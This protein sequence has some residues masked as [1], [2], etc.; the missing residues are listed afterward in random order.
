MMKSWRLALLLLAAS[1]VVMGYHDLARSSSLLTRTI[2][3]WVRHWFGGHLLAQAASVVLTGSVE[4]VS[5]VPTCTEI[6]DDGDTITHGSS[7]LGQSAQDQLCSADNVTIQTNQVTVIQ[8]SLRPGQGAEGAEE[9]RFQAFPPVDAS[10]GDADYRALFPCS[11]VPEGQPCRVFNQSALTISWRTSP[12]VSRYSLRNRGL[13]VPFAYLDYYSTI[14]ADDDQDDGPNETPVAG[15]HHTTNKRNS[16]SDRTS[17]PDCDRVPN[18]QCTDDDDSTLRI[19]SEERPLFMSQPCERNCRPDNCEGGWNDALA[20]QPAADGDDRQ[21]VGCFAC[22]AGYDKPQ[23]YPGQYGYPHRISTLQQDMVDAYS[24]LKLATTSSV[25]IDEGG[26][27]GE[28]PVTALAGSASDCQAGAAD[29][30]CIDVS[31]AQAEALLEQCSPI[32]NGERCY[33][34]FNAIQGASNGVFDQYQTQLAG[35]VS[36]SGA[37]AFD[38]LPAQAVGVAVTPFFASTRPSDQVSEPTQLTS[39]LLYRCSHGCG[40]IATGDREFGDDQ[41]AKAGNIVDAKGSMPLGPYCSAFDIDPQARG[42]I[43]VQLTLEYPGADGTLQTV[44]LDLFSDAAIG[45]SSGSAPGVTAHLEKIETTST[46]SVGRYLDGLI[47]TCGA[48]NV[49]GL[50]DGLASPDA[51][52]LDNPW[53]ALRRLAACN[54]DAASLSQPGCQ[55]YDQAMGRSTAQSPTADGE[56][57]TYSGHLPRGCAVPIPTFLN[58]I[59]TD[60]DVRA[61]RAASWFYVPPALERAYC[62]ECGCYGMPMDFGNDQSTAELICGS[63]LAG[64]PCTPGR[65][66][67]PAQ[68]AP[69]PCLSVGALAQFHARTSTVDPQGA[70]AGSSSAGVGGTCPAAGGGCAQSQDVGIPLSVPPAWD[71]TLPNWW[72]HRRALYHDANDGGDVR[73][74]LTVNVND[75]GLEADVINVANGRFVTPPAGSGYGDYCAVERGTDAGTVT[76]FV[77]NTDATL[78][79]EFCVVL[80][81][82]TDD[83]ASDDGSGVQGRK[84]GEGDGGDGQAVCDQTGTR[85]FSGSEIGS[86]IVTEVFPVDSVQCQSIAPQGV[87]A[88]TFRVN[89]DA[90]VDTR[91]TTCSAVLTTDIE[92]PSPVML[93]QAQQDCTIRQESEVSRPGDN[94]LTAALEEEGQECQAGSLVCHLAEGTWY[95]KALFWVVFGAILTL[96]LTF[97]VILIKTTYNKSVEQRLTGELVKLKEGERRLQAEAAERRRREAAARA[98]VASATTDG[99]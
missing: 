41:Q 51:S 42:V 37:A 75:L 70:A 74:R 17:D 13:H 11:Q 67:T 83:D 72:V 26:D 14:I 32:A 44:E 33:G 21:G 97:I 96:L 58:G 12:Y 85:C 47:V 56:S 38:N 48:S 16:Y 91:R 87:A 81:G 7:N 62:S 64:S 94:D 78:T 98:R 86:S 1:F 60:D 53:P 76:Y 54:A 27:L 52:P 82:C 29:D 68:G 2:G 18:T 59:Q 3:P 93:S 25:V 66:Q 28:V 36:G 5:T 34:S 50:L 89:V 31:I 4:S 23:F 71:S 73:V 19:P 6:Y 35:E 65:P 84:D 99:R 80:T 95:E 43:E 24:V 77:Q 57:T 55:S 40:S 79:A 30:S 15:G 49:D 20:D 10:S 46:G 92:Q 45:V 8:L 90:G 88:F 39:S 61:R 22:I 69:S 63:S 9:L